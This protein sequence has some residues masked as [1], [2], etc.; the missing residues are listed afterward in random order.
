MAPGAPPLI[1]ASGSAA[2]QAL[3][4]SAGLRFRVQPAAVDEAAIRSR[5]RDAGAP[6]GGALA[7]ATAKAEKVAR[8]LAIR[9]ALV[10]GADQMLVCEQHWFDKPAG[11]AAARAQLLALRGRRHELV[12]AVACWQDGQE[13]WHHVARPSLVMRRFSDSFLHAYLAA[14][15]AS[16]L[17]S[18]GAYRLEGPGVHLFERICG[19]HA[20]VLGLPMLA[21]LAFL[22]DRGVLL[23]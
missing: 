15:G 8:Q 17:Q 21:L 4:A 6:D 10:I 5:L 23:E 14:E 1:L 13:V 22:R 20:A 16:C 7:L 19:E 9:G 12:T 18:V 2:R 11:I 3:L